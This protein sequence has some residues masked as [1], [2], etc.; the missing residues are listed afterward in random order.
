M[1][2]SSV[3]V[4]AGAGDGYVRKYGGAWSGLVTTGSVTGN[5]AYPTATADYCCVCENTNPMN[6]RGFFPF[7]LSGQVPD[8]AEVVA[9]RLY[10]YVTAK[11]SAGGGTTDNNSVQVV[12][13]T[14][15]SNTT[16]ATTDFGNVGSTAFMDSR[17]PFSGF[18]TS[19]YNTFTLNAAGV[20]EVQSKSAADGY[21]VLALRGGYDLDNVA[22]TGNSN[23]QTRYSEYA[24]TTYDPYLVVEYSL[25]RTTSDTWAWN[26][27][28]TGVDTTLSGVK[29][30]KRTGQYDTWAW[31]DSAA[32]Y[33][34]NLRQP[35]VA[36]AAGPNTTLNGSQSAGAGTLTVVSTTGFDSAGTVIVIDTTDV[37][38]PY[39]QREV[40]YT[41]KTGTTFTGCTWGPDTGGSGTFPDGA[42]ASA[43]NAHNGTPQLVVLDTSA[44]PRLLMVH[45]E[46]AGHGAMITNHSVGR[47]SSD[48][49]HTWGDEFDVG[50]PR[51]NTY[52]YGRAMAAVTA[53]KNG[54]IA[55]IQFEQQWSGTPWK[56]YLT[57][58]DDDGAT[59]STPTRLTSPFDTD[60]CVP[61][62]EA[63]LD[64]GSGSDATYGDLY[65][66][67]YGTVSGGDY[68]SKLMKITDGGAGGTWTEVGTV[69]T[70]AQTDSRA[71]NEVGLVDRG[72]GTWIAHIR[73][74]AGGGDPRQRWQATSTDKGVTWTGHALAI[75]ELASHPI[76]YRTP[77]GHLISQGQEIQVGR[78][79][80]GS[81][82]TF[83]SIDGGTSWPYWRQEDTDGTYV[84]SNGGSLDTLEDLTV[85]ARRMVNAYAQENAAQSGAQIWFQW[86]ALEDFPVT[87]DTWAWSDGVTGA[88]TYA[89]ATSDTIAWSD[90][91]AGARI[92]TRTTSDS[93]AWSDTAARS[94]D[95][96]S[97]T[98]SDTWAWSDTAA[99]TYAGPHYYSRTT[100]D[101]WA[102]SDSTGALGTALYWLRAARRRSMSAPTKTYTVVQAKGT[103]RTATW[104][105]PTYESKTEAG[106]L[107]AL[108]VTAASGTGGLTLRINAHDLAGSTVIPLNTA[109]TAVT[110]IGTT[111]YALYPFGAISG[112]VTQSTSGYLPRQFSITVT[113]GDSSS[114]TYSVGYCLLP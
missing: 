24:A 11:G 109:P 20:T 23:I 92:F 13:G 91:A 85:P 7:N 68:F 95:P 76:I 111:S 4:F 57:Y 43:P 77:E 112:A 62:L 2:N 6:G 90:A 1:A 36:V 71:N 97:R 47:Y 3:S 67:V 105:S 14:P 63:M 86:Y 60:K 84:T 72:D 38:T 18:T 70:T 102:W 101:T 26:D 75:D 19:A 110:A 52:G 35:A 56:C 16:L 45:S 21:V 44:T 28:V 83:V 66:P 107:V 106:I 9:A 81:T 100:S 74:E 79:T 64:V 12:K 93:W 114:Y 25:P 58:S 40:T 8:G 113:A 108:D 48:G 30:L 34:R 104:T 37:A 78:G 87:H 50:G 103:T 73:V 98:T 69:A 27:A 96:A 5:D 82:V 51:Q 41:G 94:A 61:A 99:D 31:S 17:L 32:P 55:A 22:P 42:A 10:V 80:Y 54:R 33:W 88:V 29:T 46:A 89:R 65:I 49:G 53:L 15:A 59:W 39:Q